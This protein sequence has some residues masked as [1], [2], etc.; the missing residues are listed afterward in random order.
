MTEYGIRA[1]EY[2]AVIAARGAAVR[3]LR[4]RGR[5]LVVPFPAGAPNP[6]FRG[7][8]VAPWPNRICDGKYTFDG[9]DYELPVNEPGRNS[10]LHGFTPAMDWR[11]DSRTESAVVLSCT[12]EPTPGYPFRLA[13]TVTYSLDGDGLRGSVRA[14]NKGERAAPYGVCPH[15]YL[16]AGPAPLDEWILQFGAD[17]F[18]E[19][20]PDGRQ[21]LGSRPVAGGKLDFRVPRAIGATEIDNAFTGL[22]LDGGQGRLL[23]RDPGGTGVGMSWGPDFPWLQVYTHDREPP[24]PGRMGLAVEPMTCPPESLNTGIDLVRLEP[25]V[26]HEASWCIYAA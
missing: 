2:S 12:I 7:V 8:L 20:T 23:V 22:V 11:L 9:A 17:S 3:V 26:F 6:D 25:G 1:G 21:P 24:L 4:H 5:D 10:A 18:L 16:S 15:P 14:R 13:L 19:M